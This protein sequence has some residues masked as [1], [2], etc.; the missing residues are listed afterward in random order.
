M[1]SNCHLYEISKE[2][3]AVVSTDY[4]KCISGNTHCPTLLISHET[5]T[6]ITL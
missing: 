4:D 3:P 2:Y 6:V 5:A 1:D